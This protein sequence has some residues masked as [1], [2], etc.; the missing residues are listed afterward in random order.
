MIR[1]LTNQVFNRLT[2]IKFSHTNKGK[3]YWEAYCTCG[4]VIIVRSDN[5]TTG[6]T[7]SCGCLQSERVKNSN[8][9]HGLCAAVAVYHAYKS[10]ATKRN[11]PL[12]ITFDEFYDITSKDCYFCGCKP[13][14]TKTLR[15]SNIFIYNGIDRLNNMLGYTIE[16]CVPCCKICNIAKQQ[17]TEKD[18]YAWV[19]SVYN[20]QLTKNKL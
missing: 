19:S 5:L 9:K 17:L 10:N 14:N 13:K 1:D 11:I 2:V 6:E 4:K 20:Y 7:Q 8:T 12:S 16:N 18:F 3:T 15:K